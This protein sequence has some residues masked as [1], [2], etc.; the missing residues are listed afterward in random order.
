LKFLVDL[1]A[2][3]EIVGISR[4]SS[5]SVSTNVAAS[6]TAW[7]RPVVLACY[8]MRSR[9]P[10]WWTHAHV[11]LP[12][13]FMAERFERPPERTTRTGIGIERESKSIWNKDA[14][15]FDTPHIR[16]LSCVV[17]FVLFA[18]PA[19]LHATIP[20]RGRVSCHASQHLIKTQSA[21]VI[22]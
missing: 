12:R 15:T 4:V 14:N 18:S 7:P 9:W 6:K 8:Q 21:T 13:R 10:G 1:L 11:L 3:F 2:V 19:R 17:A 16:N 5:V 22:R 20:F